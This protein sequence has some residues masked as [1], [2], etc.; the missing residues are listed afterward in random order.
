[1]TKKIFIDISRKLYGHH[2]KIIS[3]AIFNIFDQDQ[4]G[5]ID[6]V[7]YM[8]VG[9]ISDI[10]SF[11]PISIINIGNRLQQYGQPGIEAGMDI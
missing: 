10:T 11:D 8:M 2:A 7:E 1:M 5:R 3:E 9:N 4:S 6:F